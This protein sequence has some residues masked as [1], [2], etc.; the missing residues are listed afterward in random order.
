M[1]RSGNREGLPNTIWEGAFF[2][3]HSLAVCNRE[4][5]LGLLRRRPGWD[6]G[7]FPIGKDAVGD[8]AELQPLRD[9]T[10]HVPTPLGLV[11]RMQFPADYTPPPYG[12]LIAIQPWE[13]TAVPTAWVEAVN[14]VLAEVWVPTSFVR[15]AFVDSGAN[16]DKVHVVPHGIDPGVMTPDGPALNLRTDMGF[17]FLF[18]GGTIWRKGADVLLDAYLKEFGPDE[19]VCLVIKEF[20]AQSFYRGQGLSRA[21]RR[22]MD[23]PNAPQVLYMTDE[24]GLDEV[25]K[26]YRACDALVHPFRGEGY[27]LPIA[28]AM[29]CG[30][31]AI[32]TNAGAPLDF[33]NADVA[34]LVDATERD[35]P[36]GSFKDDP[37]AGTPRVAEPDPNHLRRLMRHLFENREE[38]RSTGLRAAKHMRQHHTWDK[39]AEVME[40]RLLAFE[41]RPGEQ[42]AYATTVAALARD[43]ELRQKVGS[44]LGLTD[45]A[46]RREPHDPELVAAKGKALINMGRW[47]EAGSLMDEAGRDHPDSLPVLAQIAWMCAHSQKEQRAYGAAERAMELDG[48]DYRLTSA[49]IALYGHYTCIA[50][51]PHFTREQRKEAKRRADR[52]QQY[53]SGAGWDPASLEPLGTSLSLCMIVKNEE[54]HLPRCLDSVRGVVDQIVIVDTGSTDRTVEIARQYGAAVHHF[55]WTDDF[56]EARNESLKHATGDWI[57]WLDGDEALEQGAEKVIREAIIRPQFGGYMMQIINFMSDRE[58]KDVF[59]HRPCRLFR[60]VPAVEFTGKIHE[61]VLPSLERAGMLAANLSGARILHYGYGQAAMAEKGKLERTVRLIQAELAD[62]PSNSFQLFNLANAHYVGGRWAEAAEAFSQCAPEIHEAQDYCATAY[63]LWVGALVNDKRSAEALDVCRQADE[64][65]LANPAIEFSRASALFL[66]RR[67]EEALLAVARA[68]ELPWQDT[69]TGDFT[70]TTHK[71][72]L[73]EGQSLLGLGRVEEAIGVLEACVT[74][75]P[76]YDLGHYFLGS[77]YARTERRDE[78]LAHLERATDSPKVGDEALL[79]ISEIRSRGGE[80]LQ[81]AR[82]AARLARREPDDQ[83]AWLRWLYHAEQAEDWR[84]VNAAYSHRAERAELTADMYINWGRAAA[85]LQDWEHA[86]AHFRSAIEHG[87]TNA[88]AF[89]NA[90]DCLYQVGAYQ[91]AAEAYQTG[92]QLDPTNVEG[93]FVLGNSLFQLKMFDGAKL[94]YEQTLQLAADHTGAKN[95]LEMAE[96]AIRATAA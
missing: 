42:P 52:I 62:D 83:D 24:L 31:P 80:H 85:T 81:A 74:E 48:S 27:G 14:N 6:V 65:G 21:I 90:G 9:R 57:L 67:F 92:L 93:W 47:D 29:A 41:G 43:L 89:F 76:D 25:P 70:V 60:R 54:K 22:A 10:F 19:D 53:L 34:Y 66:E 32:I 77:A 51:S 11:V 88:N 30:L 50:R 36:P 94:A 35:V 44:D 8:R 40:A 59:T 3:T 61:Q 38:A 5:V 78:A 37:M 33:A 13:Y 4:H 46:L 71:L 2:D 86:L 75:S 64:R 28:E 96:E 16:P 91:E 56:S 39:A 84:E 95:N 82:A 12:R 7:V 26:L 87:Q 68:R 15:R 55:A 79:L 63:H 58:S 49:L 73:V 20:G 72:L 69:T 18:V 45:A 23:D 17:R 1:A